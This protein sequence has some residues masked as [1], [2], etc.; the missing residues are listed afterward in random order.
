M[1][2]NSDE[3]QLDIILDKYLDYEPWSVGWI[4]VQVHILQNMKLDGIGVITGGKRIERPKSGRRVGKLQVP[5]YTWDQYDLLVWIPRCNRAVGK[6]RRRRRARRE[7]RCYCG[8]C[9]TKGKARRWPKPVGK[10]RLLGQC[11]LYW[12][13]RKLA[14]PRSLGASRWRRTP[15][16]KRRQRWIRRRRGCCGLK[17]IP[18]PLQAP[19]PILRRRPAGPWRR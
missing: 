4:Q 2:A 16:R 9:P 5:S 3:L 15:E 1:R 8:W 14:A 13:V 19:L 10:F 7:P 11:F 6:A 18:T 12:L 17:R